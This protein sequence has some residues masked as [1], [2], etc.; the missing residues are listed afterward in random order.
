[1]SYLGTVEETAQFNFDLISCGIGIGIG[2]LLICVFIFITSKKSFSRINTVMKSILR[3]L[4]DVILVMSG[5]IF[6]VATILDVTNLIKGISLGFLN[7][8]ATVIF[9][10]LLTKKSSEF[11]FKKEQ[12]KLAKLSHRHLGDV[13]K[14]ILGLE[15]SIIDFKNTNQKEEINYQFQCLIHSLNGRIEA[16]KNGILSNKEDWYDMLSKEYRNEMEHKTD[17]EAE[18]VSPPDMSDFNPTV[19]QTNIETA[20]G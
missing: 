5:M 1:M 4:E 7:I 20:T 6:I 13:E 8:F 15:Q 11:T 17:P 9:S 3:N 10:W 14:A 19:P 2:I 12:E 18:Q 16:I